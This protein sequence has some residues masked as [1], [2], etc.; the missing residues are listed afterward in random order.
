[1]SEG[2][3]FIDRVYKPGDTVFG[4]GV[5]V[6]RPVRIVTPEYTEEGPSMSENALRGIARM[7]REKEV[8]QH[9]SRRRKKNG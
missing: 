5:I 1:M 3:R 4:I 9:H 6:D 2:R 8:R 7:I